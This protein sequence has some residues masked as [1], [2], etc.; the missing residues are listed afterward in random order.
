M[1][2]LGAG[3]AVVDIGIVKDVSGK[4]AEF[5]VGNGILGARGSFEFATDVSYCRAYSPVYTN[6]S[7]SSSGFI[8]FCNDCPIAGVY[9]VLAAT[10]RSALDTTLALRL[11]ADK[12]GAVS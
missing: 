6:I 2:R 8:N 1:N 9:F 11:N 4:R 5:D 7:A 12:F 10:L 3:K